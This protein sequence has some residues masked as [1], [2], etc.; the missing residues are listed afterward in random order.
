MKALTAIM[1]VLSVPLLILNMLGAIVSGIWLAVIG[2]W[3]PI[4]FGI[5]SFCVSSFL[6][7]FALMPGLLLIAPAAWFA[8]RRKILGV[9]VFGILSSLYNLALV[10]AW[11]C[12]ILAFFVKD[13][14]ESSL[15]PRLIWSYGLA[16]GPWSYFASKDQGEGTEGFAST[17]AVFFAQLAYLVI[18]VLVLFTSMTVLGAIEVFAGFMLVGLIIQTT[19]SVMLQLEEKRI[20]RQWG[21]NGAYF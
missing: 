18:M 11:C 17:L 4:G 7:G 2:E 19:L 10:T 16:T 9:V 5:F 20:A 15:I 3:R 13:A 14:T 6:L 12:A 8:E 1:T 21:N